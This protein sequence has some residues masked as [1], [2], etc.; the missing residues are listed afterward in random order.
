MNYLKSKDMEQTPQEKAD[1][2]ATI[3]SEYEL[4][5]KE[6]KSVKDYKEFQQIHIKVLIEVY[7]KYIPELLQAFHGMEVKKAIEKL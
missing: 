1:F 2:I 7:D 5:M 4:R 6:I 3:I